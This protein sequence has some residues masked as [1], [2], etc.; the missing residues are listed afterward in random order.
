MTGQCLKQIC[1]KVCCVF[2]M[3][4]NMYFIVIFLQTY[5]VI[6][7]HFLNMCEGNLHSKCID[8][9]VTK[10]LKHIFYII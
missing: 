3:L 10:T 8:N 4:L 5:I 6:L 1:L 7:T 2:F 9:T